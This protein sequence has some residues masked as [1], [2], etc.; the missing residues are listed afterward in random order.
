[1]TK[2]IGSFV[3][4][5]VEDEYKNLEG[6]PGVIFV[7]A[8]FEGYRDGYVVVATRAKR[9]G[10][11]H[12]SIEWVPSWGGGGLGIGVYDGARLRAFI[13]AHKN[14]RFYVFPLQ[15]GIAA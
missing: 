11:G 6:L 1:M 10:I 14:S 4:Q 8:G 5:D 2:R 3:E 12:F 13:A 9:Q 15:G 7:P